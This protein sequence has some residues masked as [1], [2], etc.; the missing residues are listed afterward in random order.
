[1]WLIMLAVAGA[2]VGLTGAGWLAV[3]RL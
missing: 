2:S 1:V 3:K